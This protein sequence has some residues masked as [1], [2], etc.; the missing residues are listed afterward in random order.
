MY[1]VDIYEGESVRVDGELIELQVYGQSISA[2]SSFKYLGVWLDAK[3][4]RS[5]HVHNRRDATQNAGNMLLTGQ[6]RIPSASH[7]FLQYLWQS[8]VFPVATYGMELFAWDSDDAAMF[9]K[10]QVSLWRRLLGI[11]ARAPAHTTGYTMDI[12]CCTIEW[13]VRRVGRLMRL[14]CAP[15]ES[16]QHV[17]LLFFLT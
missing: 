15:L 8:L 4:G 14:L 17:A 16:W 13:R 9:Q 3:G 11:G 6:F 12:S 7:G 5:S 2:S 1:V 10:V